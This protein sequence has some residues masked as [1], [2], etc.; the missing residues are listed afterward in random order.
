[1]RQRRWV[2]L[3]KDYDCIILYHIW[4]VDVVADAL[5]R[6]SMS[7]VAYI[8]EA[9]RYLIEEIHQLEVKGVTFKINELDSFVLR[10]QLKST[11]VDIMKQSQ[12][13]D[14][15]LQKIM[16]EVKSGELSNLLIG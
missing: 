9:R 16:E 14:P 15:S 13:E 12:G 3:L 10:V 11:M 1:M 7:S 2:E 6:K 8:C 4:K 5:G